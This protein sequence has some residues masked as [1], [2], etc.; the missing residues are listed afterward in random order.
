LLLITFERKMSHKG[1]KKVSH[2]IDIPRI[3]TYNQ[4]LQHFTW[5]F[6]TRRFK[7]VK[8]ADCLAVFFVLLFKSKIARKLLVKL[9]SNRFVLLDTNFK[10]SRA[11]QPLILV[12]WQL[13]QVL[14][15]NL[16]KAG[17][18]LILIFNFFLLQVAVMLQNYFL[19]PFKFLLR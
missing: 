19:F 6:Y 4:F 12:M 5:I 1:V 3:H 10:K 11:W 16:I 14:S 15:S 17:F 13:E 8:K 9:T 2:I 18:I 7:S